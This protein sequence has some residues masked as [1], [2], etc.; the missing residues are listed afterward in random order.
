MGLS[1]NKSGT[2]LGSK[3]WEYAP[4]RAGE[5][6]LELRERATYQGR[7][8][9]QHF[10]TAP[11]PPEKSPFLQPIIYNDSLYKI[12]RIANLTPNKPI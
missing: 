2:L 11:S 9:G 8:R 4:P 10:F 7:I 3:F 5:L 1:R 6:G 12:A